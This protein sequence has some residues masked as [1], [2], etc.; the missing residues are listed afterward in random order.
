MF[1]WQPHGFENEVQNKDKE[2]FLKKKKEAV[3]QTTRPN[4][5]AK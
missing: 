5:D 2:V 3:Q 4:S 1:D